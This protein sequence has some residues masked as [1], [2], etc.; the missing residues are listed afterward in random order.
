MNV[1]RMMVAVLIAAL[2]AVSSTSLALADTVA[3]QFFLGETNLGSDN[4]AEY[5][6]NNEGELRILDVGDVLRGQFDVN[7][8]EDLTGGGGTN[9]LGLVSGNNEFSGIFEVEVVAKFNPG[10]TDPCDQATCDF[11]FGPSASFEATY[12]AGALIALYEDSN[13]EYTRLDIDGNPETNL[14]LV[15]DGTLRLVLGFGLDG[16]ELWL[17]SACPEDVDVAGATP[18]PGNACAV[19]FQISILENLFPGIDFGQAAATTSLDDGLIDINASGNVLGTAGVDT[20]FDIF[21]NFD[22][23]FQP[24]QVVP[25]PSSMLL[26]GF[27]LLGLGAAVRRRIKK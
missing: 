25:E 17:A 3:S 26:L 7:T 5:L 15:T 23:V 20:A 19:N 6:I 4:S 9:A 24:N 12:G 16:D 13:I 10:T 14:A 2:F 11:V 1:K 21:D 27:G 8:I 22:F 18:P